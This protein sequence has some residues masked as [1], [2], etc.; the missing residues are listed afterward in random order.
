MALG[1][2]KKGTRVIGVLSGK[3]GVGKSV[4]S[5]NISAL[6][7]RMGKQT[8]LVDGDLSNP[9]V[10]LHLGLAYNAIGLNDCLLGKHKVSDAIVI[11][12]QTGMRVLPASLRYK[13]DFSL[14]Q[15]SRVMGELEGY[16]FVI[17]DSPP[18]LTED[19]WQIMSVCDQ[20]LLITTPD[21]PSTTAAAKTLELCKERGTEAIGVI[22]NRVT[23]AKY[24]LTPR[25]ISSMIEAPVIGEIPE[26]YAVPASIAARNPLV[27]YKPD[28]PAA[29]SFG[30]LTKRIVGDEGSFETPS[31]G[32]IAKIIAAIKRLFGR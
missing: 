12:P 9:S 32:F 3:G 11:Q 1:D 8:V 14:K 4:T 6:L 17:I 24:E 13:R 21:V 2:S 19:A 7:N 23:K 28:A 18:G 27:L 15:L 29:R 20:V 26:D 10:G 16:D 5:V 30:R 22:I 25:E 31:E